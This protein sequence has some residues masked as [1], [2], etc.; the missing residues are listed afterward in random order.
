MKTSLKCFS[1]F[2]LLFTLWTSVAR[3]GQQGYLSTSPNDRYRVYVE[4]VIDRRVGDRI[5]FRYP[6]ML[7]NV[8]RPDHHFQ[9]MDAGTPLIQETDRGTFKVKWDDLNPTQP[10]SIHFDWAADSLKFFIRLEAIEGIWKTYFVDINSGKTTE[11]T[12]DLE[13]ALVDE[14]KDEDCQ[15]PQVELIQWIKP[16]LAFIK[17]TSICGA[18]KEQINNKLFYEKASVLF[19]TDK[20]QVV[21]NCVNCKDPKSLK[22]FDKYYISTI[23]TPT[24]TPEETPT[25]Q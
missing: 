18:S 22:V 23:P 16:Y 25:A 12:A 20:G 11:I 10:T 7:V 13:K 8:R 17:L 5:F 1:A 6:M 15:Q 21:S 19:D 4:Q 9:I 24:P 14:T 3:A 2:L